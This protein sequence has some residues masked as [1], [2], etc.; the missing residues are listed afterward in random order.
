MASTLT[1]Y[2]AANLHQGVGARA[3][4]RLERLQKLPPECGSQAAALKGSKLIDTVLTSSL[5]RKDSFF[6]TSD[7][8]MGFG[9][10]DLKTSDEICCVPGCNFPLAVRCEDKSEQ[11]MDSH[12]VV[13]GEYGLLGACYVYGMMNGEVQ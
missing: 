2:Q 10:A 11:R 6:L 13:D 9:P 8:Y 5:S 7:G 4:L 1:F 3:F 12:G